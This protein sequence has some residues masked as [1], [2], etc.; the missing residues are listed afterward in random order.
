MTPKSRQMWHSA[1]FTLIELLVVIFLIGLIGSFA[2]L[3][4]NSLGDERE[5]SEELKR[6]QYKLLLASEEAI[7]QGLPMGVYF[8]EERYRFLTV[9]DGQWS[10]LGGNNAL[11]S[12]FLSNG[13]QFELRLG[14]KTVSLQT[15]EDATNELESDTK[16]QDV[17]LQP[18]P[19]TIFYSSGE[20]DPFD[21]VILNSDNVAK[22]RLWYS[23]DGVF[24]L[25]SMG[26]NAY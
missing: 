18:V 4:V 13:W 6:L 23:E 24:S 21:L 5:M 9:N 16:A 3:S 7:V 17:P 12:E 14:Q 15:S 19:Q 11:K 8:E 22:Y 20:I 10:E 1:G 2:L 25:E 26:A